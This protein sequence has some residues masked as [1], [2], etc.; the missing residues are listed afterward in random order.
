[1]RAPGP[2]LALL[3]RLLLA[4]LACSLVVAWDLQSRPAPLAAA[5]AVSATPRSTPP[6]QLART[7]QGHIPMPPDAPSAH[8]SNLL[9]MPEGHPWSLM[10]FWFAGSREAAPDV[11]IASAH[12]ERSSGTWSPARYALGR[13]DLSFGATR[14]GNPVPWLDQDGRVHLFVVATGLGGWAAGRVVHLRQRDAAAPGQPHGFAVQ[15]VLPLSWLWNYSFLVRNTPLPLRDSGMVLPAYFE[16]GD[17]GFAVALRFDAQGQM[18]SM[19]RM[20][21]DRKTIQPALLPLSATHW[22][23]LARDTSGER[24]IRVS[25]THD[26]GAHWQNA[27]NLSLPNPDASIATLQLP[28]GTMLMAHNT[29]SEGRHS[30]GLSTSANGLEWT[31]PLTAAQG[32]AGAEYSY[33]SLAWVDQHVMLSYTDQRRQ[34]AWQRFAILPATP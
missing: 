21:Q 6:V 23:A 26:A 10:A 34:I 25:Q 28:D 7:A 19:V 3:H 31:P 5:Q 1:M 16:M 4:L 30:L 17:P 24:K 11:Q 32:S 2:R 12:L 20:G 29:T 14:L 13:Q 33:P 27:P 8:A 15:R 22:L 9:V 18:R